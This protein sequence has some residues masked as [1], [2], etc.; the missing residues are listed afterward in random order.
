MW[1]SGRTEARV[2]RRWGIVG[3]GRIAAAFARAIV[4]EGDEVVAV[5]SG[6]RDRAE[7]F[8]REHGIPRAYGEHAAVT[9][10]SDV[11]VVYVATTNDR[12]HLD[13]MAAIEAGRAV[14]GE[15]PF[16]LDRDRGMGLVTAARDAGVFAMEAMWMRVQPAFIE[17]ERQIAA[18][19]IGMPRLVQADFGVAA[20]ADPTRRWRSRDLGG[21]ALMDV[22]VYPAALV[23]GLLGPPDEIIATGAVADTGVD[24]QAAVA[25]RH[26]GDALSSWSCSLVADTGVEATVAGE[27]GSLRV[28]G[29][30]HHSPRLEL[31]NRERVVQAIDVPDHDLGLRYE[32][33]EVQRCLDAGLTES[34]R[35]P[36]ELTLDVLGVLDEVRRQL[37]V[38]Y[39]S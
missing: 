7:R 29:P 32:V 14:V 1:R 30:F 21:G 2:A 19:V 16:A 24:T 11:E 28:C 15:K 5:S 38:T 3:T 18:G 17:L 10:D 33:R 31:R 27:D 13:V 25:M 39:P 23:V 4:D 12:H 8:A 36:L 6:A 22:G 35:I 34:E 9:H 37:G 20:N 26:R